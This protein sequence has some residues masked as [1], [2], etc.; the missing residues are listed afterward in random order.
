MYKKEFYHTKEE[1]YEAASIAAGEN[2]AIRDDYCTASG[3][4]YIA[5]DAINDDRDGNCLAFWAY[6]EDGCIKGVF[7]YSE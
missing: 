2:G 6:S 5:P 7:C 1:A 3:F 4:D